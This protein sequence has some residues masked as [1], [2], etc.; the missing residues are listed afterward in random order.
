MGLELRMPRTPSSVSPSGPSTISD[1]MDRS[2]EDG[3]GELT[4]PT[5]LFSWT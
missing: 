2:C 5:L 1:V 4:L 3:D